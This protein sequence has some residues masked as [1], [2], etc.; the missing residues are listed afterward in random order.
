[1]I[2]K[3]TTTFVIEIEGWYCRTKLKLARPSNDKPSQ[4][5]STLGT[6]PE[7]VNVSPSTSKATCSC[8]CH[9][10]SHKASAVPAQKG[11][12]LGTKVAAN[13][14]ESAVEVEQDSAEAKQNKSL[15]KAVHKEDEQLKLGTDDE[16][17]D[18]K[19]EE[20]EEDEDAFESDE[21]DE[22]DPKE[23][24]KK[25]KKNKK[26]SATTSKPTKKTKKVK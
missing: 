22:Y 6:K 15:K 7:S 5:L 23:K 20:D 11:E 16:N 17:D 8:S 25:T 12:A 9:S 18:E 19:D 24:N 13:L 4:P 21:S 3:Q 2:L 10:V 1:M 26:R 14:S